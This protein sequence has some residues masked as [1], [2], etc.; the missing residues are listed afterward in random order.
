MFVIDLLTYFVEI[1][2]P[3]PP[4]KKKKKK[5]YLTLFLDSLFSHT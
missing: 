2:F 3:Q 5:N 1:L 4:K